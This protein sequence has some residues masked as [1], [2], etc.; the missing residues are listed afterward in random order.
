M[1][2]AAFFEPLC[3]ADS[4]L[5]LRAGPS[6]RAPCPRGRFCTKHMFVLGEGHAACET[7]LTM[8]S[9]ASLLCPAPV[10]I[11]CSWGASVERMGQGCGSAA[12]PHYAYFRKCQAKAGCV[13]L[14]HGAALAS[15][16]HD[17]P[18]HLVPV[19]VQAGIWDGPAEHTSDTAGRGVAR[20]LAWRLCRCRRPCG[21]D[22]P[23]VC[24][25][26]SWCSPGGLFVVLISQVTDS[27]SLVT[28]SF[29]WMGGVRK[30]VMGCAVW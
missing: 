9:G 4:S 1:K 20:G 24:H 12:H 17:L 8:A 28:F 19:L 13:S 7:A 26:G 21:Q 25:H 22:R 14:L 29:K 23:C 18:V 6:S 2:R 30:G 16:T 15:H 3:H 5:L 10:P 11:G 27:A